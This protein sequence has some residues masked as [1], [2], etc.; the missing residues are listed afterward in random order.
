MFTSFQCAESPLHHRWIGRD[1]KSCRTEDRTGQQLPIEVN[2]K[3][4]KQ[5]KLFLNFELLEVD[6]QSISF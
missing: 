2:D 5:K 4:E 6:V 3:L 1:S